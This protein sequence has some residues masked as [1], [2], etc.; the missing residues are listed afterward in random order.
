[1]TVL[2]LADAKIHLN[3]SPSITTYD[4]ELQGFIDATEAIIQRRLGGPP[5]A[6][7]VSETVTPTDWGRALPLTYQPFV[8][9]TSITANGVPM[10]ISDVYATPGR[11]LRRRF[12]LPFVPWWLPPYVVTYIAGQTIAH[13]A[14]TLAAKV[15]V[16]HLWETQRGRSGGR[17]ASP[18]SEY[19]S[20]NST[21]PGYGFAV[22]NRAMEL[23]DP[24]APET[25][26]A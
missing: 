19:P 23:L 22:P 25:G 17:G 6:M 14:V 12:G 7:S 10:V 18:N 16:A 11:V 1:M 9:L 4:T 3:I 24:Y 2:S 15:M 8:S 13:P 5:V 21:V 26:L 20:P